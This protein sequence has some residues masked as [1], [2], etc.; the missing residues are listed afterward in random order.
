MDA[1]DCPKC[2][3]KYWEKCMMGEWRAVV[4]GS[5]SPEDAIY[6]VPM[7]NI[8]K[9]MTCVIVTQRG[10]VCPRKFCFATARGRCDACKT[11]DFTVFSCCQE[12]QKAEGT[13]SSEDI[14]TLKELLGKF[15]KIPEP[16]APRRLPAKFTTAPEDQFEDDIPF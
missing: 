1:H 5:H 2:G 6:S 8:E 12:V 9:C 3:A 4:Y 10:T 15:G 16:P 14:K 11:F 13:V 7:N